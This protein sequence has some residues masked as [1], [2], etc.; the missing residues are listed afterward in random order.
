MSLYSFNTKTVIELRQYYKD[1]GYKLPPKSLKQELINGLILQHVFKEMKMECLKMK[2]LRE[3]EYNS[4]ESGD[5]EDEEDEE[6][7][8]EE[9]QKDSRGYSEDEILTTLH[10]AVRSLHRNY[11]FHC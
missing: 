5:E 8:E 9:I 2:I 4:R 3:E 11:T 10:E 7:Q 1:R 6:D